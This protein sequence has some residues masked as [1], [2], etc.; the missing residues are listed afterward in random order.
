[1]TGDNGQI[2]FGQPLTQ[3]RVSPAQVERFAE[4]YTGETQGV[5]DE[6]CSQESFCRRVFRDTHARRTID[7]LQARECRQRVVADAQGTIA[8]SG[9]QPVAMH[10]QRW[11]EIELVARTA[12][13]Y[14][15]R[16]AT[17]GG[18]RIWCAGAQVV[19]FTPFTRNILQACELMLPLT[20]GRNRILI[21]LD[22]LFERDTLFL[23]QLVYQGQTPLSVTL[24]SGDVFRA[25]EPCEPARDNP[26][27]TL[28]AMM[29]SDDFHGDA[30]ALLLSSLKRISAREHGSE[31]LLVPLLELV[32]GNAGA[33]FSPLL[34]R[35]V[36]S[37]VLGYRYGRDERGNDVMVFDGET[38]TL[39]FYAAQYL[40]GQ[41]WPEARFIASGRTG[42]A[43]Q[44]LANDRLRQWFAREHTGGQ[45][46]DYAGLFALARWA[47]DKALRRT[48]QQLVHRLFPHAYHAGDAK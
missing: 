17:C 5:D 48:A 18:V 12:G 16:L 31:A 19:C 28:L 7:P 4:F 27:L 36:R 13:D 40:A 22:E 2:R 32:A 23:L 21:H 11:L 20:V 46:D 45:P 44:A 34:W 41:C 35:R 29:Q 39:A 14:P 38:A 9:Y 30:N 25:Q 10:V 37:T 42:Q 15:F 8:F 1:M 47:E 6:T 24:L 43:Q 3:F 26:A 33:H